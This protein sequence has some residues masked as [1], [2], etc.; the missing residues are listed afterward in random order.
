MRIWRFR[1]RE[2]RE[3]MAFHQE[4]LEGEGL[5]PRQAERMLGNDL[6]LRE[7]AR[8]AWGWRW[9]EA[10]GRDMRLALRQMRKAPGFT[11]VVVLTLALGIGANTAVF[12]VLSATLLRPL[13][14]RDPGQLTMLY[15]VAKHP[16]NDL[17]DV[18]TNAGLPLV[19]A[20]GNGYKFGLSE[21]YS[22]SFPDFVALRNAAQ[23]VASAMFGFAQAG[24]CIVLVDGNASK[25]DGSMVTEEYFSGLGLE[26]ERGRLL[27]GGDFTAGAAQAVVIS[28]AFW[29]EHFG[30]RADAVGKVIMVN[31]HPA[32]IIGITP[33]GFTGLEPGRADAFW[34]PAAAADPLLPWSLRPEGGSAYESSQYWWLQ[35]MARRRRGVSEARLL[36][37]LA[38]VFNAAAAGEVRALLKPGDDAPQLRVHR[39]AQGIND[40]ADAFGPTLTLLMAGAGVLLLL[41]CVNVAILL[42]A[43]SSARRKEIAV[44]LA[45]GARRRRLIGQLLTESVLLALTGGAAGVA[46][47][48]AVAGALDAMLA[49]R[50]LTPVPPSLDWRVL[51]AALAAALAAGVG[52]GIA[53]ALSSTRLHL[54]DAMKPGP[55]ERGHGMLRDQSLVVA[56]T[57]LSLLLLVGAGLLARTLL[58]FERQPLGFDP[59]HV[60]T[61]RIDGPAA[62]Y[63]AEELPAFYLN[64]QHRLRA[65]PGVEAVGVA[66]H[67]LLGGDIGGIAVRVPASSDP[68]LLRGA[69]RNN[70]GPGFF[71]ALRIPLLRGRAIDER[72]VQNRAAVTVVNEALARKFFGGAEPLGQR[73]VLPAPGGRS[74]AFTVVGVVADTRFGALGGGFPATAFFPYTSLG[75]VHDL[76]F[77]VRAGRSPDSIVG[78]VRQV[79]SELNPGIVMDRFQTQ[80]EQDFSTLG[81]QR[82]LAKLAAAFA[83]LGLLLAAI[84]ME[85]TMAYAVVRRTRDIG[86]RMALGAD[87][88][89]VARAVARE[90][91][92]IAG[93]GAAAGAAASLALGKLIGAQLYGVSV[94]D[95]LTLAAA[96]TVLLAVA[97]LAAWLPARRAAAVDPLKALRCE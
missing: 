41:A 67:T 84:G 40:S 14:V 76:T 24:N 8:D 81:S 37:A 4:Q 20:R 52:F 22:I 32:T 29:G 3:E 69:K 50:Y 55:A 31:R 27:D 11:A 68:A 46:L 66:Q 58:N 87:R 79:L 28:D 43:R 15:W 91:L 35:V 72:D 90:A 61:F 86:V 51:S 60:V 39:G 78:Q 42:L 59:S 9:L 88:G 56:Q 36:A 77:A 89:Q 48:P 62:G 25:A 74:T 7:R 75:A 44:R 49:S 18:G 57:A 23:P 30:R 45:L 65:M 92:V 93:C 21:M 38:P 73:I 34:V 64:L 85:G 2:V 5:S 82:L 47:A 80:V 96:A 97:G 16:P 10:L 83:L 12:S 71:A 6:L 33:A 54:T 26:A 53:P 17:N 94:R 63:R 13:P 95:P 1:S 19:G 70:I